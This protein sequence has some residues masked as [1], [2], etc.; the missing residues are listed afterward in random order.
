LTAV[1]SCG[2]VYATTSSGV[3]HFI[4]STFFWGSL[5]SDWTLEPTPAGAEYV[6][7]S[8]Y[9]EVRCAVPM[10]IRGRVA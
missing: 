2:A 9:R 8:R 3:S 5:R 1:H 6:L 10:S 4:Q 7:E